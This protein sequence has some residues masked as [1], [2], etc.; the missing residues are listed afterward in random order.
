MT[1]PERPRDEPPADQTQVLPPGTF[2]RVPAASPSTEPPLLSGRPSTDPPLYGGRQD[3][4]PPLYGGRGDGESRSDAEPPLFGGAGSSQDDVAT[5]QHSPFDSRPQS[6]T[7][8]TQY[9]S[10]SPA[11]APWSGGQQAAPSLPPTQP[12]PYAPE[13]AP[14]QPQYPGAAPMVIAP[15]AVVVPVA[16]QQSRGATGW[17]S[18]LVGLLVAVAGLFLFTRFGFHAL[19]TDR[20][21]T[22]LI[23]AGLGAALLFAAA[24]LNCWSGWATLLPGV[25]F[26]GLGGLMFFDGPGNTWSW[27]ADGLSFAFDENMLVY[28]GVSG[29]LMMIGLLLLGASIAAF[30]ARRSGRREVTPAATADRVS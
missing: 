29:L 21:L 17:L 4:E 9:L 8:S 19:Q 26:A 11:N 2:G 15:Q 23:A 3:A 16:G 30:V 28:V 5:R 6:D 7:E 18:L 24:L 13:P 20:S 22:N 25:L 14:Y 10:K 27:L 12:P 1:G